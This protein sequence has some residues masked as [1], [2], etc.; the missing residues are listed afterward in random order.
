MPNY[1]RNIPR[2]PDPVRTGVARMYINADGDLVIEYAS[3]NIVVLDTSGGTGGGTLPIILDGETA[4]IALVNDQDGGDAFGSFGT[5]INAG[6]A[7][8]NMTPP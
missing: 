6:G 1:R 3:G 8:L 5:D 2:T 4:T 7:F